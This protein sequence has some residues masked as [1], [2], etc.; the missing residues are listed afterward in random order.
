MKNGFQNYAKPGSAAVMTTRFARRGILQRQC[1]CG[2]ASGPDGEC[3]ECKKKGLQRKAAA[4]PA[5]QAGA[6]APPIVHEVLRSPGQP[7]EAAT[8]AFMEPRLGHDFS[9]VRVHANGASAEA[10]R[11]VSARAYALGQ[12]IVFG[13]GEFAPD[14]WEGQRLLAHELTH[15]LQQRGEAP[16]VGKAGIPIGEPG[17]VS[18]QEADRV[19]A[20][21][22]RTGPEGGPAGHSRK[23]GPIS[24]RN[25]SAVQRAPMGGLDDSET[26]EP[27]PRSHGGVLPYRETTELLNCISIMG[28]ENTPYCRFK[29]L[30]EPQCPAGLPGAGNSFFGQ[31]IPAVSKTLRSKLLEAQSRAMQ[32]MCLAGKKPDDFR[33]TKPIGTYPKHSPAMDKAVDIDLKGQ[34]FIMHEHGEPEI[35]AEIGPVYDRIAFWS[36][37]RKSIIPHG[38]TSVAQSPQSSGA[39][40]TWT[41]PETGAK[42]EPV[43]TGEL[44]DKLSQESTGMQGY[45]NLLTKSDAD[46]GIEVGA[47]LEFNPDPVANLSKLELPAES[48]AAAVQ[49][50]RQRIANDYRLLGGSHAQ[51]EAL[52]GKT[53]A[54]ASITPKAQPG[55]RPFAGGVP[56][57]TTAKDGAPDPNQDRRPELGFLTLPKEVVVALTEVGLVWGA[58]D[59]GG[60]SGDVMHFDCRNIPGC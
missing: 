46:L 7:L 21:V 4:P 41:N 55:D 36:H 12:H 39:Q 56:A 54:D 43:T 31:S 42:Q 33:L 13:A 22:M 38:I 59:F 58:I 32:A 14:K 34:P 2:G 10:A 28:E 53:I 11:A 57:G 19:A 45:F 3:E 51:L 47:F 48:T 9:Q 37:Y 15:V 24:R 50:F 35:D 23:S 18:E 26:K 20:S 25:G 30:G 44:Y 29:V 1:A 6:V 60:E 27:L 17:D 16:P 40:R 8:R 5:V 52:A 49:S